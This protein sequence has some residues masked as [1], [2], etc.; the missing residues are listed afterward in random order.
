[1]NPEPK[2][3]YPG[4]RLIRTVVAVMAGIGLLVGCMTP[5]GQ[6]ALRPYRPDSQG[7]N[8]AQW[9]AAPSGDSVK[10]PAVPNVRPQLP[11]EPRVAT[12][13]VRRLKT[14]DKV[15]ISLRGITP[16]EEINEV[17][18]HM[19]LITLP[20]IGDIKV[21]G[22]TTS[23]AEQ[24]IVRTYLE[25]GI[26]RKI[27]VILVVGDEE[28]FVQGEVKREGRFPLS[29][30]DMTLLQAVAMAGGFT[31][32]AKD[33]EVQIKRGNQVIQVDVRRIRDLKDK[34][35]GIFPSD[36]IYVPRRVFL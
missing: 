17:V 10:V 30:R 5:P 16:P 25:K 29:S 11:D 8:P 14:D 2:T 15:T 31:D 18:D 26:Y 12:G 24:R 22:M 4:D 33:T 13:G 19:G 21:D 1:M 35:P 20:H 34:D 3:V 27:T 9:T 28:F 7:R 23:E 36:V 6:A 32:F